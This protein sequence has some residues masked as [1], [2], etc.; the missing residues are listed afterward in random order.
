MEAAIS[1][2]GVSKRFCVNHARQSN[3]DDYRTLRD[4]IAHLLAVPLRNIRQGAALGHVEDF[5]ALR[6]ITFD[7]RVGEVVGLIGRNGAG[8]STLLKILTRITL[9]TVGRARLTGRVGSLLEVGTGFH[10]ELTGRENVFLN[11]AILGMGR[12]EIREK[13]AAIVDFSGVERFI[14]TPFKRYSSGMKVRLGFAVAAHLDLDSLLVDEVLAVGDADFQ[15]KCLG[16]MRDVV[17]SGRSVIFV[18]HNMS[19]VRS[20]CDRLLLLDNG[21]I[22]ADGAPELVIPEYL[23]GESFGTSTSAEKRYADCDA[24]RRDGVVLHAIRT[25]DENGKLRSHFHNLEPVFVEL[26]FT[27]VRRLTN[28]KVGFEVKNASYDLLFQSFACDEEYVLPP[29]PEPNVRFCLKAAI[30]RRFLNEGTFYV[31]P[32]IGIHGERWFIRDRH[33]VEISIRFDTPNRERTIRVRR[34]MVAPILDWSLN[35]VNAR[36][37]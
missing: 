2:V 8:K 36:T 26:E 32:V 33:G 29:S 23:N 25:L 6:D 30:P 11:G 3:Q 4:S 7:V 22:V 5:W 1:V 12:R 9:P 18:S 20:L 13:F 35:R 24:D 37:A 21:R 14:D 19:A 34:G 27:L 10:P 15:R 17:G 28:L 31:Q 16:K